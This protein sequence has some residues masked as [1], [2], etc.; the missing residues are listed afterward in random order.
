MGINAPKG[1]DYYLN[2]NAIN[3]FHRFNDSLGGTWEELELGCSKT[4]TKFASEACL[5]MLCNAECATGYNYFHKINIKDDE[6]DPCYI[7]NENLDDPFTGERV[8]IFPKII[9]CSLTFDGG[10]VANI[11]RQFLSMCTCWIKF[12]CL[13]PGLKHTYYSCCP[14]FISKYNEDHPQV[15]KLY[16]EKSDELGAKGRFEIWIPE[17][18]CWIFINYENVGGNMDLKARNHVLHNS[19]AVGGNYGMVQ[20]TQINKHRYPQVQTVHKHDFTYTLFDKFISP[21]DLKN[22]NILNM[23]GSFYTLTTK[24]LGDIMYDKLKELIDMCI[25][26]KENESDSSDVEDITEESKMDLTKQCAQ[27]LKAGILGELPADAFLM[28]S[29]IKHPLWSYIKFNV[30]LLLSIFKN[31]WYWSDEKIIQCV[32][33]FEVDKLTKQ[34]NN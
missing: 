24:L 1:Q 18:K 7:N 16:K 26:Q 13:I 8:Y 23:H 34:V 28:I 11:P 3:R 15:L 27:E 2:R 33:I 14:I 22:K 21:R 6:I 12:D 5:S 31:I 25:E 9:H 17:K 19:V 20:A 30:G 32:E 10:P 4:N 29:D